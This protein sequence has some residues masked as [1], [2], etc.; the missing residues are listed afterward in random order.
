MKKIMFDDMELIE[1]DTF[2]DDPDETVNVLRLKQG[3]KVTDEL[4]FSDDEL[5][6]LY[7]LLKSSLERKGMIKL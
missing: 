3:E 5:R 4:Y 1:Q 6:E 2:S 7:V